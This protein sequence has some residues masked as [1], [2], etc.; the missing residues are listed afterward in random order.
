MEKA[1]IKKSVSHS[2]STSPSFSETANSMFISS[3][4]KADNNGQRNKTK[5]GSFDKNS[6]DSDTQASSSMKNQ[7]L[8]FK[9]ITNKNYK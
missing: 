9:Q 2:N 1:K 7:I 5:K 8:Q 4:N 3:V 6:S